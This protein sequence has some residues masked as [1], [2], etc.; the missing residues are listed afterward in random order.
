MDSRYFLIIGATAACG[1]AAALT[2]LVASGA[3]MIGLVDLPNARNVHSRPTPRVGG[4]A[5]G[6]ASV[7]VALALILI[8]GVRTGSTT[9]AE[10]LM[11]ATSAISILLFGLLDDIFS[12]PS[13]VKLL[14]L[15]A[16]AAATCGVG[17]RIDQLIL[18]GAPVMT[19]GHMTW[20]ITVFWIVAITV[21]IN[22]IDGL[23]GLAGGIG[24]IA[25][26]VIAITAIVGGVYPIALL[27]LALAGALG[28]F[29]IF[30]VHPAR[31]FMG[32]CGSMFVGFVLAVLSVMLQRD[33]GTMQGLCLPAIA[34]SIPLL[35]TFFTIVRRGIIDRRSIFRA[36]RGHIHHRLMDHQGLHHP[37][38]V[39]VLWAVSLMA[40]IL[41]AVALLNKG[42]ATVAGL[43][44]LVPLLTGLF[45][46][47][48][49]VR[50]RHTLIAMRRNRS[51][52]R[53][54]RSN[55]AI[56]DEMQNR[57]R[58]A[59][60]FETWWQTLSDAANELRCLSLSLPMSRRDGTPQH[61]T[62]RNDE[63]QAVDDATTA[64]HA[65]VPVPQRRAS[66]P[67]RAEIIVSSVDGLET[68]GQ[69]LAMLSRLLA[70]HGLDTLSSDGRNRPPSLRLRLVGM[71]GA[72]DRPTNATASE[73]GGPLPPSREKPRVAVVHDFL[74]TYAGAEKVLEQILNVYPDAELFSLFDFLPA[75]GRG[76]IRDKK[77]HSSFIQHLPFAK[78]K[79]RLYLP[80]MPLAIEQLDMSGFDIVIS[81]S[82]LAA[83]GVITK[84]SQLH[85][86]YCHSP[87]RY[88][89]DLQGEYLKTSNMAHGLKSI[90][91]KSIL[92]YLRIWDTRSANGVDH[93]LTNSDF[94]GRRVE[95]I[96]RRK[97]TTLYPPVDVE[98]F[99]TNVA[100]EDFYLAASR[101]VPYKRMDL[102]I[103]A[104]KRMPGKRLVIVGTGPEYD[105]LAAIAPPNVRLVG[106][107]LQADLARYMQLSKG[108]I[109]AAEEDFGIVLVE[110][111]ACGTPVIA[112]GRGGARE[113]VA[114][115]E[116]GLF[117]HRQRAED[118]VAAV[119][120]FE[121]REWDTAR[122]RA[123]AERFNV[124]RFR[125]ELHEFVDRHWQDFA[126][127]LGLEAAQVAQPDAE[128][129]SAS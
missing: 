55:Q 85:I 16:A 29:L 11:F 28:G 106:H 84:P 79:H 5:I 88:A 50:L 9:S 49:S 95:K 109:F 73:Q 86:C 24:M 120:E 96:Y 71:G 26:G 45:R 107:V 1:A 46:T 78:K 64:L 51:A 14:V 61:M 15:V 65:T 22:F 17:I 38:A 125:D 127:R 117:F 47:A 108:F 94:V 77:V 98:T 33:V 37:H 56:F 110:A 90:V 91:A 75:D 87:A 100:R 129:A 52:N 21:A 82:Y 81:S 104:F 57:F 4:I 35:D 74:Y 42:W 67:L 76:F 12:I 101:L 54:R 123:Q 115:N 116:T 119:Q 128:T 41:G 60:D 7:G 18:H 36:E 43:L 126:D 89:W 39:I 112:F 83:K 31:I 6:I 121:T 68:A 58:I 70:E 2:P 93:F 63:L 69:R 19:F 114:E 30:N 99:A 122:I 53:V 66:G 13:K 72:I 113:I 20:P 62:W 124:G 80:L 97:S 27:A 102:I 3:R 105:H 118:I 111:H 23:D 44:M 103:E 10:L 25:A 40:S 34:L 92:H 8:G 48:G 32:D 59:R